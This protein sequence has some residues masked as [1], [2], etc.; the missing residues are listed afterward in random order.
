[1]VKKQKNLRLE[2]S[3][4]QELKLEAVKQKTNDSKLVERYIKEGLLKD[5]Q[6]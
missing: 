6:K 2:E 1:M 4:I 5:N 3:L